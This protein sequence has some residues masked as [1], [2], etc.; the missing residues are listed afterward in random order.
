VNSRS[1]IIP[2]RD[3]RE[4]TQFLRSLASFGIRRGEYRLGERMIPARSAASSRERS[5]TLL[6]K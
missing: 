1:P 4:R 6:E 3:I 2:S 5:P